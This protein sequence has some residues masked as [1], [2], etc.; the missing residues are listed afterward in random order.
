V[1]PTRRRRD[2]EGRSE[3]RGLRERPPAGA[4]TEPADL[5]KGT[6]RYRIHTNRLSVVVAFRSEQEVVIVTAWRNK[7]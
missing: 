2:A 6:W 5:V 7:Q 4:V 1:L 3:P